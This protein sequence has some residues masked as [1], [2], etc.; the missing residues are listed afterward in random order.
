MIFHGA[1]RQS[2]S[3]S[4]FAS[5]PLPHNQRA[6]CECATSGGGF[7][8]FRK[9][10]TVLLAAAVISGGLAT[11]PASAATKISNGVSCSKLNQNKTVSGYKYK[12]VKNPLVKNAKL[13]WLSSECITAAS[14]WTAAV[15]AQAQFATGSAA[16]AEN[17]AAEQALSK[18]TAE[19]AAAA[20]AAAAQE[21][22]IAAKKDAEEVA[23]MAAEIQF[24]DAGP[25]SVM[26]Q[27]ALRR[28]EV[29]DRLAAEADK[30][31]Q[32]AAARRRAEEEERR[33]KEEQEKAAL[34]RQAEVAAGLKK[35]REEQAARRAAQEAAAKATI[36]AAAARE[37]QRKKEQEEAIEAQRRRLEAE[38]K[39]AAEDAAALVAARRK[40]EEEE[41]RKRE[42]QE[43]AAGAREAE[44][45]QKRREEQATQ[46]AAQEAAAKAAIARGLQQD[47]QIRRARQEAVSAEQRRIEALNIAKEVAQMVERISSKNNVPCNE[48][49]QEVLHVLKQ[50]EE[51]QRKEEERLARELLAK[52][53]E[54]AA[55]MASEI[56]SKDI[57]CSNQEFKKVL[58]VLQRIEEA[59][60]EDEQRQQ[61]LR[62]QEQRLAGEQPQVFSCLP[63]M[64][65]P[66][67]HSA[68]LTTLLL[69]C[70]F[71]L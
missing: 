63:D 9:V 59:Q 24:K 3:I 22:A 57:V 50:I 6:R 15:K 71:T 65:L 66:A 34:A 37:E 43:K 18:K 42:E 45:L 53:A 33:K 28:I 44:R 21:K 46:R 29:A 39:K 41:R 10:S 64:C 4:N 14:Q 58:Q 49:F 35:R 8:M 48:E 68:P 19:E 52:E 67:Y 55:Q 11:V 70:F 36:A 62:Q 5:I 2:A 25:S 13:T 23:Q 1:M 30:A 26:M 17:K 54:E 32:E 56:Q 40:A 20:A 38:Q 60:R 27:Q 47:E 7:S 69:G 12:C 31:E 61:E 51:Q 16:A